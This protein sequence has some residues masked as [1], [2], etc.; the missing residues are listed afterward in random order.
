MRDGPATSTAPH[1]PDRHLAVY[2]ELIEL[3]ALLR[4]AEGGLPQRSPVR[5]WLARI[6]DD[7]LDVAADLLLAHAD[8]AEGPR[9]EPSRSSWLEDARLEALS[10]LPTIRP[11][12]AV[13]PFDSAGWLR[14]A[15]AAADRAA[16][17][18]RAA[19]VDGR[20][21]PFVPDYLQRLAELL[22]VLSR[23]AGL[24]TTVR[25]TR[26]PGRVVLFPQRAVPSCG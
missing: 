15:A 5:R 25:P 3:K 2:E 17:S 23:F 14:L 4:L 9:L 12:R 18:A 20:S 7:L 6:Q 8:P 24:D 22:R 11:F 21:N 26:R 13:S 10:L 1:A 16:D 19:A